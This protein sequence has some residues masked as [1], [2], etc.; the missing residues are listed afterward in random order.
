MVF[1]FCTKSLINDYVYKV[2]S[3]V[4]SKTDSFELIILKNSKYKCPSQKNTFDLVSWNLKPFNPNTIDSVSLV[5]MGFPS[6]IIN[7]LLRFKKAGGKFKK[8][9]D[10]KK[11]YSI[12]DSIFN[13]FSS[14]IIIPIS[15]QKKD[16]KKKQLFVDTIKVGLN[17]AS[18]SQLAYIKGIGEVL[19]RRIVQ[20]RKLLGGFYSTKQILEVYG[21]DSLLY[22]NIERHIYIDSLIIEK[23][24]FNEIQF[25]ELVSHPYITG[26]KASTMLRY[27]QMRGKIDSIQEFIDYKILSK[28]EC[29][30]LSNYFY[31]KK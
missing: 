9:D 21:I 5:N 8:V 6:K 1:R 31:V 18:E 29:E 26:Y 28:S 30:I 10:V 4:I 17:L 19:A 27:R 23:K 15:S 11:L 16:I 14:Y 25:K 7:N 22:C 2:D 20:Y 3:V 13:I 12:S 24:N